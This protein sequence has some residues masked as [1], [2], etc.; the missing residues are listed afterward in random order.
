[1]NNFSTGVDASQI[2][3][4]TMNL[5]T[6]TGDNWELTPVIA[7]FNLTDKTV[8]FNKPVALLVKTEWGSQWLTEAKDITPELQFRV[9]KREAENQGLLP[10]PHS[11]HPWA[12]LRDS[13]GY[14][15]RYKPTSQVEIKTIPLIN[16]EWIAAFIAAGGKLDSMGVWGIS[17]YAVHLEKYEATFVARILLA[18]HQQ[19][20]D[21][22]DHLFQMEGVTIN[23]DISYRELR[24]LRLGYARNQQL[25]EYRVQHSYSLM[26]LGWM[27]EEKFY[28]FLY[29]NA[30]PSRA[31]TQ[32]CHHAMWRGYYN[33]TEKLELVAPEVLELAARAALKKHNKIKEDYTNLPKTLYSGKLALAYY[34]MQYPTVNGKP[35][36]VFTGFRKQLQDCCPTVWNALMGKKAGTYVLTNGKIYKTRLVGSVRV[37]KIDSIVYGAD[38][39]ASG[40]LN[41]KKFSTVRE[42]VERLS[43]GKFDSIA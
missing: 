2:K 23:P 13:R 29:T 19:R 34:R 42:A 35:K 17:P 43:S 40:L 32:D 16:R 36:R 10:E 37:V 4:V 12:N 27:S 26:R 15:S 8:R 30:Q 5:H 3:C 1:M 24:V 31:L 21:N 7:T 14:L 41:Y 39:T 22:C 25:A 38:T 33:G 9:A 11:H 18:A 6:Q 28:T 20:W